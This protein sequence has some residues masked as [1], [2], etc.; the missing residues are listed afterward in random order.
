MG[1]IQLVIEDVDDVIEQVYRRFGVRRVIRS[2]LRAMTRR[3]HYNNA[4]ANLSDRML[5]DVGMP[6][7]E[8]RF[9]VH[10]LDVILP[11]F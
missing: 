3:R 1:K 8:K 2:L 10:P 11:P 6:L 5:R 7:K 9:P 4:L